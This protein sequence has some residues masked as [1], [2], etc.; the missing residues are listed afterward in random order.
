MFSSLLEKLSRVTS[1]GRY[2]PEVDG[3]RFL[4]IFLVLVFHALRSMVPENYD[5]A[6]SDSILLSM[7][8]NGLYGVHL[9][10][11]ISG[12][13][14]ALPFVQHFCQGGKK[15]GLK[16]YFIRR[17]TRLEP[18]YIIVMTAFYGLAWVM[19][20]YPREVLIPHYLSAL[21][22]LHGAI[23]HTRGLINSVAWSLEVEVQFYILAPFI[24]YVFALPKLKRRVLLL[25]L[26]MVFPILQITYSW[27][28]LNI[29]GQLQFFLAGVL[30]ADLYQNERQWLEVR[31]IEYD[32]LALL[33]L[34]SILLLPREPAFYRFLL[35]FL[36]LALYTGLFKSK[37]LIKFFRLKVIAV[38]GGMCYSIYLLHLPIMSELVA[39]LSST[40]TTQ[41]FF[42][43]FVLY[44]AVVIPLIIGVSAVFFVLIEKPC[45]K[46]DWHKDLWYKLSGSKKEQLNG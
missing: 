18:P 33:S 30:L 25:I 21:T 26:M 23:Y 14:L 24:F 11:G 5:T 34:L 8:D 13:I 2:I 20:V 46:K 32:L 27:S 10:F 38:I 43:D 39:K 7:A 12:F 6:V 16:A 17:L 22:Y 44:S 9:F 41:N 40:Y 45:M 1:T 42:Y 36:I 15:V 35:A 3:F 28:D 31:S 29:A 37:I 19:A 4:A